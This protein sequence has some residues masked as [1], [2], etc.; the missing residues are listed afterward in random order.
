MGR[1]VTD[2]RSI[3]AALERAGWKDGAEAL[4][5]GWVEHREGELEWEE[6]WEPDDRCR[7]ISNC[8]TGERFVVEWVA[9]DTWELSIAWPEG[10]GRE[11]LRMGFLEDLQDAAA[12]IHET[13][14]PFGGP[15]VLPCGH[16]PCQLPACGLPHQ[17][18]Q[19]LTGDVELRFELL[20][21]DLAAYFFITREGSL[22][23]LWIIRFNPAHL[24]A[25][26]ESLEHTPRSDP[27]LW[28][29]AQGRRRAW[30]FTGWRPLLARVPLAGL[31]LLLACPDSSTAIILAHAAGRL[32]TAVQ[33]E[34]SELADFDAGRWLATAPPWPRA[35]RD[36]D[37]AGPPP[38]P[39]TSPPSTPATAAAPTRA[40][41]LRGPATRIEPGAARAAEPVPPRPVVAPEP[42]VPPSPT[43]LPAPA[44]TAPGA[45][46]PPP[47]GS[48]TKIEP[49][50]AQVA[51]LAAPEPV[52]VAS[53]PPPPMAP[54]PTSD[55]VPEVAPQPSGSPTHSA[56]AGPSKLLEPVPSP[57]KQATPRFPLA[58]GASAEELQRH[59][60]EVEAAIPPRLTGTATAVE[61]WK[62]VREAHAEGA[63][64]IT[65]NWVDL[66]ASLHRRGF[67]AHLPSDRASRAALVILAD[68]SP[69][70]RR[71]HHRRWILGGDH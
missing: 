37:A 25:A 6:T 62:A 64:P 42:V 61:L 2:A 51:E 18:G 44:P 21:R 3:E 59:F 33:I 57:P 70:V 15:Q 1:L 5:T 11:H 35:R 55:A 27:K 50:A 32:E 34:M 7:Y 43:R 58:A 28:V 23:N 41:P 67:L 16:C 54:P 14:G 31:E 63:L 19:R 12:K 48:A 10:W 40:P 49:G 52:M 8:P 45:S 68:L 38:P 22:N 26:L 66:V 29:L 4:V 69:L 24:P 47:T 36:L 30:S 39:R 20:R 17:R 56:D 65:G 13:E 71:L 9:G 60:S 46:S 53:E